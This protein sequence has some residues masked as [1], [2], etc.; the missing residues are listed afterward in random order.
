MLLFLIFSTSVFR[1]CEYM[2]IYSIHV[3]RIC[4]H[5]TRRKLLLRAFDLKKKKTNKH[6]IRLRLGTNK[7]KTVFAANNVF[8]TKRFI[9]WHVIGDHKN[10]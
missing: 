9:R 3:V 8:V 7:S 10:T 5:E 6:K 4:C 2:Y 1:P